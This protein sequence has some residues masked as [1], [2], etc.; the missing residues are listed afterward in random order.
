MSAGAEAAGVKVGMSA[1]QAEVACPEA[2]LREEAPAR[3]NARHQ[4][5]LQG[6]QSLTPMVEATR[7]G[8]YYLGMKGMSWLFRDEGALLEGALL[9]GVGV[10][11]EA[12]AGAAGS[13]FAALIAAQVA[14]PGRYRQVQPKEDAAFLASLPL[15]MLP[16]APVLLERLKLVGLET[17]GELARLSPRAVERRYGSEGISLYRLARAEDGVHLFPSLPP[18]HYGQNLL[19]EYPVEQAEGLIFLLSPLVERL[20][21]TLRQEGRACAAL[22]LRLR[23]QRAETPELANLSLDVPL[24]TPVTQARPLLDLLRLKL[25]R[26]E[27]DAG[28]VEASLCATKVTD[29]S[30]PQGDLFQRVGSPSGM[31]VTLARLVDALGPE[32]VSIGQIT[33]GFR[34]DRTYTLRSVLEGA[35]ALLEAAQKNTST[36][37]PKP[38]PT[39]PEPRPSP[40]TGP[41][42]PAAHPALKKKSTPPPA[43][44]RETPPREPRTATPELSLPPGFRRVEPTL[45]LE[46]IEDDDGPIAVLTNNRRRQVLTRQGP[47]RYAGLWWEQT[48]ARDYFAIVLGDKTELLIYR[49]LNQ[50]MDQSMDQNLDQNLDQKSSTRE[51]YLEGIYD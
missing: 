38:R 22:Q 40:E 36:R 24:G 43:L 4:Q 26:L 28:V 32:N 18:A 19:L 21:E 33:D 14:L 17:I 11:L 35:P 41:S 9:E 13:R 23:L 29:P 44:T 16:I 39:R 34:P 6:L 50:S 47:F 49:N 27:L 42:I 5:L 10:G 46:V 15:S 45:R 48:Y 37:A 20:L 25:A 30:T 31:A 2:L 12:T 1:A 51:W 3:Y 7:L 8:L